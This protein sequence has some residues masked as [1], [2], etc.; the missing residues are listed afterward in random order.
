[1]DKGVKTKDMK[2]LSRRG[3]EARGGEWTAPETA[4][5]APDGQNSA[6]RSRGSLNRGILKNVGG[7]RSVFF[8]RDSERFYPSPA[9]FAR[10]YQKTILEAS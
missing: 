2:H 8:T 5:T 6:G 1:M 9:E 10:V 3:D 4:R 7:R